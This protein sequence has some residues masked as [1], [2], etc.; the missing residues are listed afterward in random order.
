M[1]DT[2]GNTERTEDIALVSQSLQSSKLGK[3][4]TCKAS[5]SG[6]T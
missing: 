1:Q 6:T 5:V 3:W 2:R 4:L